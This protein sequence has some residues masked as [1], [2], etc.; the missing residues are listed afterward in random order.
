ME[1]IIIFSSFFNPLKRYFLCLISIAI[2][3]SSFAQP[4]SDSAIIAKHLRGI[5]RVFGNRDFSNIYSLNKTADYIKEEFER[6]ADTAFFQEFVVN[7]QTYKNVL[8]S[9]GKDNSQRIIIGAH[10]DVCDEQEGADD[11]ASGVVGLLELARLLKNQN[12]KYRIDLVAYTLEEPPFFGSEQMGSFFHAKSLVDNKI[13]VYGMVSIEMIGYFRDDKNSQEYPVKFFKLLYG[14]K[15]NYITIVRKFGS[16]K[17]ARK[18][19]RAYKKA[20]VIR[21]KKFIGPVWIP[22]ID[23]SDHRCYWNSGISALMLTDTSF[24]RNKNYH[25]KTDT[26]ETLDISRMSKVIDGVFL[27]LKKINN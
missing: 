20:K 6:F 13:P 26:M 18:F 23:F 17:F 16:G 10:Y 25:Q 24:Y 3:Q 14:S 1:I 11:N 21:T 27:A 19:T 5:T 4:F 9:F 12:L 8:C 15:G 7:D 2:F 22:G